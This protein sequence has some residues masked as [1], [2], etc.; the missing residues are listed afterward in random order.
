MP[1]ADAFLRSVVADP[2]AD[3]P[4]LAYAD[5]LAETGQSPRAEFIRV[6]SARAALAEGERELHPLRKRERSLLAGHYGEWVRPICELVLSDDSTLRGWRRWLPGRRKRARFH[7]E[8]RRGFVEVLHL[9][10]TAFLRH[11]AELV[12]MTPLRKL[13]LDVRDTP[14]ITGT[15]TAVIDCPHLSGLT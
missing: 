7:A 13:G 9:D 1:T 8:F 15:F 4:R 5:W 14:D 12:N 6:Q 10:P 3:A 2:D 11:A